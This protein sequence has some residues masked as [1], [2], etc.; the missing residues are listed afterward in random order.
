MTTY[1]HKKSLRHTTDEQFSEN[2]TVDGSRLDRAMEEVV[3]HYNDIPA[4]DMLTRF[5]ETKYVFGY[6]ANREYKTTLTAPAGVYYYAHHWPW[7]PIANNAY[8]TGSENPATGNGHTEEWQNQYLVKGADLGMQS[9]TNAGRFLP[10]V[11]AGT[12]GEDWNRSIA[13]HIGTDDYTTVAGPESGYQFAWTISHY[14]SKAVFVNDLMVNFFNGDE[15]AG[16]RGIRAPFNIGGADRGAYTVSVCIM[17]DDFFTAEKRDNAS[18]ELAAHKYDLGSL[19]WTM[20]AHA[21]GY[22]DMNPPHQDGQLRGRSWRWRDLNIPVPERSRVRLILTIP[23]ARAG[24]ADT[25]LTWNNSAIAPFHCFDPG[26][27]L[28][29]LEEIEE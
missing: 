19:K 10:T 5:V 7:V 20:G 14:F 21:A 28:T 17:V 16:A 3:G 8:T 15:R 18:V 9:V 24:A 27:C 1:S 13:N 4:G 12:W 25:G 6:R 23:W 22:T 29:V 26:G 2:T 11:G